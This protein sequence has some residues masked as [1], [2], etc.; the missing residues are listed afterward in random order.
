MAPAAAMELD[1]GSMGI[2]ATA[3]AAAAEVAAPANVKRKGKNTGPATEARRRQAAKRRR[4]NQVKQGTAASAAAAAA[5][6]ERERVRQHRAL[7]QHWQR[8]DQDFFRP[9]TK[10]DIACLE[11]QVCGWGRWHGSACPD[12][13]HTA[14]SFAL[15]L[16]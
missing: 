6:A 15:A 4:L 13:A 7:V 5:A 8:V 14:L 16:R 10:A 9:V 2:P 12:T 1:E 3:P 11:E